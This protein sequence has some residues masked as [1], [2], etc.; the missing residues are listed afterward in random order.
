MRKKDEAMAKKEQLCIE[1]ERRKSAAEERAKRAEALV[2]SQQQ[3]HV[4][5][6]LSI[7]PTPQNNLSYIS[8]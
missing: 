2:K 3:N 4:R 8:W 6:H 5:I 7:F 1:L